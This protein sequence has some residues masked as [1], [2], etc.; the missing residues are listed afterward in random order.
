MFGGLN[1]KQTSLLAEVLK[2]INDGKQNDLISVNLIE[3]QEVVNELNTL[4]NNSKAIKKWAKRSVEN[5][6][7]ETVELK[8]NDQELASALKE[9]Q[10]SYLNLKAESEQQAREIETRTKLVDEMCI[11]SETESTKAPT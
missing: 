2:N 4:I 11:V 1:K 8:G 10:A 5:H 3:N 7:Q 9:V 6:F